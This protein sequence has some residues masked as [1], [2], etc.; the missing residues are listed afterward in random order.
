MKLLLCFGTRPEAIKMAPICHRLKEMKIDFKICITAQHREMLDQVI[1]FFEII[2]DYDLDLMHKNQSLNHLS[3]LIFK[4]IDNVLDLEEP[5]FVLVQGDTTTAVM[6][7]LAAFHRGIKVAHVEAGL[8]TYQKHS[9]FPEEVNR[10]IISRIADLH[11][12]P[13]TE[14]KTN[15]LKE[16]IKEEQIF[17]TG[18]TVVDALEWAH[19]KKKQLPPSKEMEKI[20]SRLLREK[21]VILVTGHRRENIG[22]GIKNICEALIEIA[23]KQEVQIIFPVHLNPKVK[24]PVIHILG[25]NP[26]IH[27]IKP[28]SYPTM[29]W[30]MEQADLLIS[31]SGGIQ[32][33]VPTYKKPLLVTRDFSER[34][35]GVN[36]GF[37]VLVG[38]DKKKIVEEAIR[39]LI[40]PP[41]LRLIPNPF[42]DGKAA[43]K[44]VDA[45]FQNKF[46]A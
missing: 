13:T 16:E 4:E 41:D 33:E 20:N 35:E 15:L 12:V 22:D 42:G 2:P 6:V 21:K 1:D 36:A 23:E 10:Q 11:F 39:I 28:V 5:N 37:S 25:N 27:L 29:L 3:S 40:N 43:D 8:R 30:L 19:E 17:F 31:D 18:N 26:N 32:E 34:M 7:A 44:I 45:I 46:P 9:P 14:A 38:T 24:E